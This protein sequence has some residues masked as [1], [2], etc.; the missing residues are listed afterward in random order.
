MRRLSFFSSPGTMRTPAALGGMLAHSGAKMPA[1]RRS[2]SYNAAAELRQAYA[3]ELRLAWLQDGM[4][5]AG[6]RMQDRLQE[7]GLQDGRPAGAA[8]PLAY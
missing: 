2:V 4:Q 6:C 7:G 5:D 1:S 3:A 8:D